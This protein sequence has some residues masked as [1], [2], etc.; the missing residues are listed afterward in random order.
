M[1]DQPQHQELHVVGPEESAE[2]F[3]EYPRSYNPRPCRRG[4]PSS[5]WLSFFVCI[6]AYY[7]HISNRGTWQTER[8]DEEG[9]PGVL[10]KVVVVSGLGSVP[11][12]GRN[13][14]E[15]S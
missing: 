15:Q 14:Y 9:P 10:A 3:R 1:P 13:E 7:Y 5:E 12:K 2:R 8:M 4:N 6:C 11:G